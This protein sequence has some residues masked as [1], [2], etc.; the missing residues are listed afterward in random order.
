M[1]IITTITYQLIHNTQCTMNFDYK[2]HKKQ[3]TVFLQSSGNVLLTEN[4]DF[5]ISAILACLRCIKMF[6]S[7]RRVLKSINIIWH[8]ALLNIIDI[9]YYREKLF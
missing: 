1:K 3:H 5:S 2:V 9:I 6:F 7:A 4:A 8:S